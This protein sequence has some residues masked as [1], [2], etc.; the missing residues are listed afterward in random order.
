MVKEEPNNSYITGQPCVR[1]GKLGFAV[2]RE[3]KGA[4]WRYLWRS[5]EHRGNYN[6]RVTHTIDYPSS[7]GPYDVI[8]LLPK[9]LSMVLP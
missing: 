8:I 9:G 2:A 4:E 3:E 1:K 7:H 6:N 5:A